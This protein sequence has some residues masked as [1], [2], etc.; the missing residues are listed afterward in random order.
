[1]IR[2]SGIS[3]PAPKKLDKQT[4]CFLRVDEFD[5]PELAFDLFD[6]IDLVKIFRT[7][8]TW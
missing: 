5:V 6:L 7:A 2:I 8:M 3:N 4:I 1:M